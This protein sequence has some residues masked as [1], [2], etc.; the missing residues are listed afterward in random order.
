VSTSAKSVSISAPR[1]WKRSAG[2]DETV[3]GR[4]TPVT[5]TRHLVALRQASRP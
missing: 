4:V 2:P 1:F 3:R 5:L